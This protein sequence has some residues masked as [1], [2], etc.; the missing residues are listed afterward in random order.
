MIELISIVVNYKTH[1]LLE[2]FIESYV[3]YVD[4]DNRRLIVADISPPVTA[5]LPGNFGYYSWDE[6][7]GYA[8]SVNY[9]ANLYRNQE[10]YPHAALGIFNADT[11]FTNRNCV[12]SCLDLLNSND[13]VGIVG[14]LQTNK[15]GQ[16]THAGIFGTNKDPLHRGWK[17]K[18]P[19]LYKDIKDAVYVSGSAMFVK[20]EV[21][22][23][24]TDDPEYRDF[25]P[26]AEGALLSTPLYYEDTWLCQF[27]RHRGYRVL[28]N[29]EAEMIHLHDS[30]PTSALKGATVA[31]RKIFREACDRVGMEHV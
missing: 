7:V 8:R 1:D 4:T 20:R 10:M 27:A 6:N 13:D 12:D 29:G 16:V 26:E 11:E 30:S 17:S 15:S 23:S 21:W 14:P 22:D 3:K 31:S 5:S 9:I 18:K 19:D 28:Y 25:D 2:K 24:L